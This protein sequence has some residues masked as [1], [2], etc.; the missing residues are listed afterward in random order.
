MAWFSFQK[1]KSPDHDCCSR[2]S[3]HVAL[4]LS[5]GFAGIVISFM[6]F[7][8]PV[9]MLMV[10]Y[11]LVKT[12]ST[13]ILAINGIGCFIETVYIAL[14]LVFAPR[15][16][17]IA[18]VKLLVLLNVVA[19]GAI[20]CLTLL[21]L[22]RSTRVHVIGWINVGFSVSVFAAPLGVMRHV[23]RTRSVDSLPFNLSCFLTV[24]AIVWFAYG[25]L[26]GDP[27]VAAPNVLGFLFGVAQIVLYIVYRDAS[28]R[29]ASEAKEDPEKGTVSQEGKLV[30]VNKPASMAGGSEVHPIEA[31]LHV[32]HGEGEADQRQVH[33]EDGDGKNAAVLGE[34]VQRSTPP[35]V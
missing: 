4:I 28:C 3:F 11:A 33:R 29:Q 12:H 23:I 17:R 24:S 32:V 22:K 19:Y 34:E 25:F 35:P 13:L 14:F 16:A 30:L 5:F 7:L 18:T 27:Y 6:V 2:I 31:K 26:I 8:A 9:A 15:K 1:F 21:L 20:V 10:Y